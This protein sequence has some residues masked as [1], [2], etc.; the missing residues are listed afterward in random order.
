MTSKSLQSLIRQNTHYVLAN[1]GGISQDESLRT[2]PGGA[3]PFNWI[4]G[5]LC[6]WRSSLLSM[7]GLEPLWA[8]DEGASYRGHP[9]ERRPL[10]FDPTSALPISRL[11]ADFQAM[12]KRLE[13]WTESASDLDL[14]DHFLNLLLHE[15]YHAGQLGV[16]RRA[17]GRDGVI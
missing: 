12:H 16:L 5:H 4:V 13:E 9:E 17:I 10:D 2:S 8:E 6:F 7:S 3:N 1:A 11:T 14:P 15:A